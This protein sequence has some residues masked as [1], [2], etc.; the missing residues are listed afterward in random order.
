MCGRI[1]SQT[2]HL[3]SAIGAINWGLVAFMNFNI[4]LYLSVLLG[5]PYLEQLLYGLIGISGLYSLVY[6][7]IGCSS[8]K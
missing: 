3:L 1:F 6:M 4:A 8:C 2:A 7:F 5:V